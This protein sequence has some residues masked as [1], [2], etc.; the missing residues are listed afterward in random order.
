LNA[1]GIDARFF[2]F[3]RSEGQQ[4]MAL[5]IEEIQAPEVGV[6]LFVARMDGRGIDFDVDFRLRDIGI[7]QLQIA[8]DGSKFARIMK[9]C[10]L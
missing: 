6:A 2:D 8:A 3:G 10:L 7:V 5:R 1:E 4:G 9:S